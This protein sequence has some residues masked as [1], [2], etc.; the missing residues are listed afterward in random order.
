M[1]NL[2]KIILVIASFYLRICYLFLPL[3]NGFRGFF[4]I[5]NLNLE[6]DEIAV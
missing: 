6:K 1:K 3:S 2:E 5:F 4:F